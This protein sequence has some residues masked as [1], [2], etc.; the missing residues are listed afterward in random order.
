MKKNPA[1]LKE[2]NNCV[3]YVLVLLFTTYMF[4]TSVWAQERK[5]IYDVMRNGN[6]I[7]K[8]IF[9]ELTKDG[10]QFLSFTSDIKTNFIFSFSDQTTET[11]TFENE[12]LIRSS[13]YQKQTGSDKTNL[14]IEATENMYKFIN[15]GSSKM[16][17]D[18]PIYYNTLLLYV[19]PPENIYKAYSLK[20]QKLLEI[21]KLEENKY[22]LSLPDG[23]YNYYTYKDGVCKKVEVERTFFSVQFV[24]RD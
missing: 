12:I 14:V 4:Q 10:K 18:Y 19:K 6:L 8:I 5:L 7:G 24:L 3:K 1:F 11:S 21:K 22:R 20:F 2:I 9:T 16:I 17:Y 23:N 13:L 15:G